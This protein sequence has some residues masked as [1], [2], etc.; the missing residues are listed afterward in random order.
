MWQS[1][2]KSGTDG[3]KFSHSGRTDWYDELMAGSPSSQGV[4]STAPIFLRMMSCGGQLGDPSSELHAGRI[5]ALTNAKN[6]N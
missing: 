4:R 2:T 1:V 5:S 6:K 3:R